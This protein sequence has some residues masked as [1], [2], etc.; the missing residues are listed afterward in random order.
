MSAKVEFHVRGLFVGSMTPVM[1][2]I[3]HCA[4]K[5]LTSAGLQDFEGSTPSFATFGAHFLPN[6][7][8]N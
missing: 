7:C 4:R 8:V 2:K 1:Q 5:E 3:S 6:C